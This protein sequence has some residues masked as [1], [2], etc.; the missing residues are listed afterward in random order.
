MRTMEAQNQLLLMMAQKM[1]LGVEA[2]EAVQLKP[3]ILGANAS[4]DEK[5]DIEIEVARL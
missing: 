2:E 3:S 5:D 4:S 1:D